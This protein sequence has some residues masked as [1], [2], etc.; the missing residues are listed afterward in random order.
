MLTWQVADG[1]G[2]AA[3]QR[4]HTQ[5]EVTVD[6]HLTRSRDDLLSLHACDGPIQAP[7]A[8]QLLFHPSGLPDQQAEGV[9]PLAGGLILRPQLFEVAGHLC[10]G[11]FE[12]GLKGE[13]R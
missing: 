7:G 13:L 1:I 3:G 8:D 10:G 11:K 5:R 9:C 6:H 2:N 12:G 4:R